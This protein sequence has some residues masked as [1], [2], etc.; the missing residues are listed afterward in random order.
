MSESESRDV[1]GEM[2]YAPAEGDPVSTESR[3]MVSGTMIGDFVNIADDGRSVEN[4]V[5]DP[6]EEV[7]GD[8]GPSGGTSGSK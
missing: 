6:M 4:D 2:A 1:M 5:P 7:G 3:A 8:G